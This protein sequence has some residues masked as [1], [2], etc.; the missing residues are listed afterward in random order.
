VRKQI[1]SALL[2]AVVFLGLAMPALADGII[3][4]RPRPHEPVP[5]LRSLAIKYHRVTV[6]IKDQ[7]ATTHVEQ[8][9]INES[10][11]E[12]EGEYIFPLPE[13]ASISQFAMWVDGQRLEAEVLEANK[14]RQIYEDIVR[15]QRD[16]ALLEY[17]GRNA[18]RAR[19]YPIPAH[20]EKRVEL[21]YTEV[22]PQDH[23]LVRYIYPLNTEKFSTRPLEQVSIS[24]R[25]TSR[26]TVKAVYSPSHE[27]D[28]V[29]GDDG[30]VKAS[31]EQMNVTP[32]KD[33]VLYY[34]VS[35]EDLG[36]N[37][38]SYKEGKED[39]FFLLLLAPKARLEQQEVVAKDV[40]F[41][42]D[43]SGSMRGKKIAQ[44]KEAARYVLD[45]LNEED[46]F[47]II[48]FGTQVNA[49]DRSLQPLTKVERARSFINSLTATGGTNIYQALEEALSQTQGS[50]PQVIIFLTDGLA[51]EGEVRTEKI[52]EMVNDRAKEN[53]RIFTFGVGYEVNTTLLDTVSQSHH[54]TGSYVRPDEDLEQ[55]LSSFY[56]KISTPVLADVAID[57]GQ[58]RVSDTYPY[59]LPDLFA[60][61][62]LIIVGRY[63]QG[64]TTTVTLRG[65]VNG[66]PMS[67]AFKDISFRSSGGEDLIPRLWA[68][69]KIGYL[70]T[71]IRLHGAE[72]ELVDEIVE[73]SV[74]Y[75]IVTPY[76]SFL[77]DET[78]DA[79]ST[80]GRRSIAERELEAA[81]PQAP[82]MGGAAPA[83]TAAAGKAAVEK[84]VAQDSLRRAEVPAESAS[85]QVRTVGD[86]TFVLRNEVWTDTLYDTGKMK[87]EEV[88]FG[89]ERYFQLLRQY[90]QWGRFLALGPQ[91]IL[92]WEDKA[93]YIG[94][95][96]EANPRREAT[97]TVTP[98]PNTPT[99]APT[100]T[101][102]PVQNP[103]QRL[104][105]WWRGLL[106]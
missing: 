21:E 20:S 91:V 45:N 14:A 101:P 70:L 1:A 92:V 48:A 77:V 69:R 2:V 7:V 15:Q 85:A 9:F 39:G 10:A 25:I 88:A 79:L 75:G 43:T 99:A 8:V 89:S 30:T 93:Y 24:V 22:L 95:S 87:A 72:R 51:T 38:L 68:T 12:I 18:F 59:P 96:G 42:L 40:F 47:N 44:A 4:P 82:G 73:L 6:T 32:D 90:P 83:P 74:R 16:P 19:I 63:R 97:P 35:E 104:L 56:E 57:F 78:E 76:T 98:I 46:R 62:Q 29:R 31:Y 84:S 100:P 80:N 36:V 37:L 66:K 27:V 23:G 5:P 61:G 106:L 50:R 17:A 65:T 67:Y 52:I 58:V 11:Q 86:K 60:G 41:V 81:R 13:E 55:A 71:Q 26:Q 33:F 3:I 54:G 53:V 102:A 105:E 94:A 49:F 64:D 103:W 34:T 28:V